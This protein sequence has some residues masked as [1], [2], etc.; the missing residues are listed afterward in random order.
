ME[1]DDL[2]H[3]KA[4]PRKKPKPKIR[5][6]LKFYPA[7]YEEPPKKYEGPTRQDGDQRNNENSNPKAPLPYYM[8]YNPENGTY[9]TLQ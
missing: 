6:A 9:F 4:K 2:I 8:K 7:N 3:V 1:R 5:T